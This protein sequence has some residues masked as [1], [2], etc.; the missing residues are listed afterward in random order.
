MVLNIISLIVWVVLG[1]LVLCQ[2]EVS[3]WDYAIAWLV[4]ILYIINN[5][6]Y[7]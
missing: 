2:K 4:L 6:I 5:F 7:L 3:K 1:Y